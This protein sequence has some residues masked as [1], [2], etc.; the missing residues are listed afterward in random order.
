MSNHWVFIC[1]H[2]P[3]EAIGSHHLELYFFS[4]S[5]VHEGNWLYQ[6]YYTCETF[7]M[8][9][10]KPFV[11][12]SYL[13][14]P[15]YSI[16][17]RELNSSKKW[18]CHLRFSRKHYQFYNEFHWGGVLFILGYA[19][20]GRG[21][22]G[23]GFHWPV[24]GFWFKYIRERTDEWISV[25]GRSSLCN[26]SFPPPFF[27]AWSQPLFFIWS[28]FSFSKHWMT[29]KPSVFFT[30]LFTFFHR[31]LVILLDF[32]YWCVEKGKGNYIWRVLI[33]IIIHWNCY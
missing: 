28:L 17:R 25:R 5:H 19:F 6:N 11:L 13:F 23:E 14:V 10:F 18:S 24:P 26:P 32:R 33:S 30:R 29:I 20:Q 21:L 8:L 9:H 31:V 15:Y 3:Q 2:I 4:Y 22:K 27:L 16:W 7:K 1:A 12:Y